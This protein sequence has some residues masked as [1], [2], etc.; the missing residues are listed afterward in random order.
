MGRAPPNNIFLDKNYPISHFLCISIPTP[1]ENTDSMEEDF[2]GDFR[3]STDADSLPVERGGEAKRYIKAPSENRHFNCLGHNI[4]VFHMK[5]SLSG[6][7]G[8]SYFSMIRR[9][10]S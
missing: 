8:V 2:G 4:G 3:L 9:G 1:A 5:D 7:L 10:R 6:N